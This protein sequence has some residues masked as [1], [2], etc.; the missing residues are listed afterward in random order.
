MSLL[1]ECKCHGVSGSCTMKTCWKTLPGFRQVGDNLMKKYYRARPV[2]SS[3]SS[4][5]PRGIDSYRRPRKIHLVLKKGKMAIKKMPK[6]S[7]LVFLQMSPNYCERDLAAGSLGTV[8]RTC[9]RTSRGTD[10]CDLM[11]C[12][13]GYNTHQYTKTWQCRCKFHWCCYVDCDTCSERTEE[14]TCK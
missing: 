1:T 2:T 11:C 14:Y 10:G 3:P 6:K 4:P 7:D 12:G 5:G 13:R 8:G 9:N